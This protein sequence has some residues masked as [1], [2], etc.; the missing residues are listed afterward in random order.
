MQPDEF[1]TR[2][3]EARASAILRTSAAEA[4]GGAM[5]AAIRAGFTI[6]EF[7]LT[8][9]GAMDLIG[10]FALREG[11]VVGAGTV[12]SPDEALNAVEAGAEF[13]VAPVV[14]EA[15]IEEAR[16]LGVAVMPGAFT[17]TEML[18]AHRAG[19]SLV[20][21]F[22]APGTGPTYVKSILAAMPFLRIVPTNGVHENNAAAY[23][24]AGALAVGFTTALFDANEI[25]AGQFDRI[26]ERARKL[27]AAAGASAR[28]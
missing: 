5:E 17:A 4:A 8:T 11:I 9:P 14:D 18:A 27:L 13:L 16:R 19:A 6:V 22:P 21:L 12:L 25:Q 20:K 24:K 7:T 28:S 10:A 3:H 2:Y 26:E 1:V 23:L 15:V